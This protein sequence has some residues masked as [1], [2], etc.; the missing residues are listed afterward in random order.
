M[1]ISH[2]TLAEAIEWCG[3]HLDYDAIAV[4][5]EYGT[6]HYAKFREDTP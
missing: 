2:N 4:Y 1:N 6:C 3:D 5:D